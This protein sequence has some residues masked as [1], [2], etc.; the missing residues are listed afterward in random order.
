[1]E[2]GGGGGDGG[3][4]LFR[5]D[6]FF[7][8][9]LVT[10]QTALKPTEQSWGSYILSFGIFMST[11][12][13]VRARTSRT[14]LACCF[15]ASHTPLIPEQYILRDIETSEISIVWYWQLSHKPL[16]CVPSFI[17]EILKPGH[18]LV[19]ISASA[20]EAQGEKVLNP[21]KDNIH[22]VLFDQRLP[23]LTAAI[24]IA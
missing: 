24:H 9:V 11:N 17:D 21:R 22:V 7:G 3:I 10:Q 14:W 8:G 13:H 2:S 6:V 16:C 4:V 15:P 19:G 12:E 23:V 20:L 18:Q 5:V 1:M